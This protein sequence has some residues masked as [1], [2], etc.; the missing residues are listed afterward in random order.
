[1]PCS[2][3]AL[4]YAIQFGIPFVV[5]AFALGWVSGRFAERRRRSVE[6]AAGAAGV[7]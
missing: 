1:M 3:E 7:R 6:R 4:T 5:I 2:G